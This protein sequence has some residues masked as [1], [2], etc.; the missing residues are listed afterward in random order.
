MLKNDESVTV[1]RYALDFKGPTLIVEYITNT[2]K[3]FHRKIRFKRYPTDVDPERVANKL[4]KQ[5]DD[6]LGVDRVSRDQ[7]FELVN[8]LLSSTPMAMN[9]KKAFFA[10]D[11]DGVVKED[12]HEDMFGDLNKVTEEENVRAKKT[13]DVTFAANVIKPGD[14]EYI[15]DKVVEF[16]DPAESCDWDDDDD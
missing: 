14:D 6:I 10:G 5:F 3:V 16:G 13:M 7:V 4:M 12:A 8:I 11:E 9:G 2:D 15:Y 1:R